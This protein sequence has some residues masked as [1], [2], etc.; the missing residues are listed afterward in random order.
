LFDH[1]IRNRLHLPPVSASEHHKEIGEGG[2][3]AQIQN[4]RLDRFLFSRSLEHAHDSFVQI[5]HPQDSR[6]RFAAQ[7]GRPHLRTQRFFA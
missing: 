5:G 3:T 1:L 6:R 7:R 2:N 4:S